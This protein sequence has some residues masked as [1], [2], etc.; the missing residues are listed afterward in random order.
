M[1]AC[2]H[3]FIHPTQ[4]NP[5]QPLEINWAGAADGHLVNIDWNQYHWYIVADQAKYGD[6]N[7]QWKEL[8]AQIISF[9]F[10]WDLKL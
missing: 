10:Q 7:R 3:A 6:Y 5:T 8:L 1:Y 2:M 9:V 4:P